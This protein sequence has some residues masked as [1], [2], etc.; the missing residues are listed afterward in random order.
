MFNDR[1][2]AGQQLARAL[3]GHTGPGALVLGLP[4]GGVVVAEVVARQL[5]LR[6][7]VYVVRKL[8]APGNP[9]FAV[10]ALAEDGPPLLD[11]SI[12]RSLGIA[13]DYVNE[14]VNAQ[15]REIERQVHLYRGGRPIE[16]IAGNEVVVVD[17]GIATGATV[18]AAVLGVRHQQPSR[19]VVAAPVCSTRA[20]E[21]LSEDSDEVV[22][23][24]APEDFWAVGQFYRHFDQV[25]DATVVSGLQKAHGPARGTGD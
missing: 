3:E 17:D 24:E 15:R 1:E 16:D 12:V 19:V 4:R 11:E 18:R 14:E 6:L 25:D 9:E 7:G 8:R 5:G 20:V 21:L 13:D 10:G 22:V 2:S 23:V